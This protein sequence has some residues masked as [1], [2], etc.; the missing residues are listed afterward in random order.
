MVVWSSLSCCRYTAVELQVCLSFLVKML[1]HLP[2]CPTHFSLDRSSGPMTLLPKI[3]QLTITPAVGPSNGK[4][5][6]SQHR[7]VACVAILWGCVFHNL[8]VEPRNGCSSITFADQGKVLSIE[9]TRLGLLISILVC[10]RLICSSCQAWRS[11]TLWAAS[12]I[13]VRFSPRMTTNR[14][15]SL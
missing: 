12:Y 10:R 2:V 1:L 13:L 9:I 15:S 3:R 14:P 8:L 11:R 6:A 4:S 7:W 5:I